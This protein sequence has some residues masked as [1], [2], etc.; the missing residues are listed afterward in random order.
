MKKKGFEAILSL[1][2]WVVNCLDHELV[3]V[4]TSLVHFYFLISGL[5]FSVALMGA[6]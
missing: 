6:Q 4:E 2:H 1:A 3:V 5:S